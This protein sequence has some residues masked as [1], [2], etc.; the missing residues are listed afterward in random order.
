VQI[1]S[2][3]ESEAYLPTHSNLVDLELDRIPGAEGKSHRV[4][5]LALGG[6]DVPAAP[7]LRL[8]LVDELEVVL[9]ED[10]GD[11]SWRD[12]VG[13]LARVDR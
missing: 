11:E 13:T 9:A 12:R 3:I 8:V 4:T 7:L 5:A 6:V 1:Y 10:L 2:A